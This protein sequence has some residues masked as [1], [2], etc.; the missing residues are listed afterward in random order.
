MNDFGTAGGPISG[1][2]ARPVD[3]GYPPESLTSVGNVADGVDT[4]KANKGTHFGNNDAN[5]AH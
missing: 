3:G 4:S 2:V 5:R 1:N